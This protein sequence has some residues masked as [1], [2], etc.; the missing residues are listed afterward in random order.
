MKRKVLTNIT[1]TKNRPLQLDGYLRSLYRFLPSQWMQTY[2]IYKEE[3]F[4]SEYESVFRRFPGIEVIRESDFH[5]NTI[6]VLDRVDTEYVLFGID[7]V[8]FF[9]G[10]RWEVI[11]KTFEEEGD[12]V[13]GFAQRFG[14]ETVRQDGD[15]IDEV[16]VGNETVYRLRWANGQTKHTR[17]PF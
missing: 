1:F 10:L 2:I 11:E 17:Y 4:D 7:D 6:D 12:D 3:L 14:P 15:E 8:V 5:R 13:F 9:D 16:P